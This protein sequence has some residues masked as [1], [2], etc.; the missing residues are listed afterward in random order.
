VDDHAPSVSS[1]AGERV[2]ET[3]RDGPGPTVTACCADRRV[4]HVDNYACVFVLKEFVGLV[5]ESFQ[6]QTYS[7]GSGEWSVGEILRFVMHRPI[8]H[9]LIRTLLHNFE[10]DQLVT[11]DEPFESPEFIERAEAADL[12]YPIIIIRYDDGLWVADGLHR[13]WKAKSLG[14]TNIA[15]F[16]MDAHELQDIPQVS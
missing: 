7:D 15:A 9:I 12:S 2:S 8:R 3:P 14:R 5:V 1:R 4:S 13:L 10:P 11:T 16:V 6:D